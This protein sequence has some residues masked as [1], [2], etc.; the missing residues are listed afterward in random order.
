[1]IKKEFIIQSKTNE[2]SYYNNLIIKKE[3]ISLQLSEFEEKKLGRKI[4]TTN[5]EFIP[6]NCNEL[7]KLAFEIIGRIGSDQAILTIYNNS[8]TSVLKIFRNPD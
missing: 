5:F 3:Q 8:D 1:M 2:I 6:E 4:T 7:S